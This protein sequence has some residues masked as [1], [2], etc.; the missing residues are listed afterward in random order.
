MWCFQTFLSY[1]L[2]CHIMV[3]VCRGCH[4]LRGFCLSFYCLVNSWYECCPEI[5]KLDIH[6]K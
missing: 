6:L 1:Q 4:H 5:N 2:I 3:L